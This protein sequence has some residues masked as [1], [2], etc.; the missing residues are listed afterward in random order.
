MLVHDINDAK[1]PDSTLKTKDH[2]FDNFV[3]ICGTVRI[4][5]DGFAGYELFVTERP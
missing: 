2:Q 3:V 5:R 4:T 1:H